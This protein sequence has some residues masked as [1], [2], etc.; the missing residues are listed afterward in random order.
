MQFNYHTHTELCGHA[1]GEMREYVESA[2][3]GGLK[4]LGFSDNAPQLFTDGRAYRDGTRM[5][6]E[7]INEYA[8]NV[9]ALAKEYEKDIRIL[10]G[11]E[12][13]YYPDNYAEEKVFLSQV[14]PDY[15]IL[16]QHFIGDESTGFHVYGQSSDD[17]VLT[18]YVTQVLAALN[19]GDF[20]YVAHP[21]MAGFRYSE[22]AIEREYTRLCIG[23]KKRGIPLEINLWGLRGERAYP[24][25]R[26]FEI[27]AKVGNEVA[28]GFDAHTPEVFTDENLKAR[29]RAF[30]QAL[31][32]KVIEKPLI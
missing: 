31:G 20:L 26:F 1:K 22:Q 15:L 13:E 24:N 27:A 10:L 11:F 14:K 7:R 18:A 19:T 6:P 30:A 5:R 12:L 8:D 16:G 9:R 2:I 21:D 17:F 28:F 23:A 29:G 25:S 4:T 3:A 32:L